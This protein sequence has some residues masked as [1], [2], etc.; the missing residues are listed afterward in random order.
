MSQT[1][2]CVN[3]SPSLTAVITSGSFINPPSDFLTTRIVIDINND[4]TSYN[5]TMQGTAN[6]IARNITFIVSVDETNLISL[7]NNN[8]GVSITFPRGTTGSHS[9]PCRP[10]NVANATT[11]DIKFDIYEYQIDMLTCCFGT[12]G[13]VVLFATRANFTISSNLEANDLNIDTI[14]CIGCGCL[15]IGDCTNFE[16]P[17]IQI[18]AQTLVDGSDVGD[19]IFIICDEIK[20]KNHNGTISIPNNCCKTRTI[21]CVKVKQTRFDK[22][23][24]K[25]VCVVRGKGDTLREKVQ[26]IYSRFAGSETG[27]SFQTFYEH[28]ILYALAKY[29]L[30]NLLWVKS[31]EFKVKFLLQ[32]YHSEF[33]CSLTQS[34][35]CAFINFFYG[36]DSIVIGYDKYFRKC[37]KQC[38]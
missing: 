15:A 30:A 13:V 36:S 12:E 38:D 11:V 32:K 9:S 35:F 7:S 6:G 20:Y 8:P 24:I 29:I 2:T 17:Q 18:T 3:Y 16:I 31:G 22:C 10:F 33:I 34:R 26:D 21:N 5:V 25:L 28:I 23:C 4:I 19:A 27:I 37:E 1:R 14:P